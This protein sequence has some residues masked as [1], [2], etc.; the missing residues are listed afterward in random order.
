MQPGRLAKAPIV[1]YNSHRHKKSLMALLYLI[2]HARSQM[3][4]DAAQRWPLSEQGRRE[5]GVLSR[6]NFWREVGLIFASP[7][8]KALQTAGPA[9]RRWGIPLEAVDCLHELCR[10][11][12]IHNYETIIARLF[13]E[14]ETSIIGLEPAAQAADRITRCLKELVAAHPE[15]TLAVVSHGL[16]LTI[17]LARLKNHWPTVAEWRAIPFTGLA[18]VD[19]TTWCL[20]KNWSSVSEAF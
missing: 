1:C 10:P 8:P 17:F 9:A 11:Q 20:I 3:M 16:V 15:Q 18:V 19:T 12:L 2:R 5:A 14:P 4:G 7:E 13:A 6:Q